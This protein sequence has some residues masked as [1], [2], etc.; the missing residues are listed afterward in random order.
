MIRPPKLPDSLRKERQCSASLIEERLEV[1][2]Q[3]MFDAADVG[4]KPLTA[5]PQSEKGWSVI[6]KTR[7]GAMYR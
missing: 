6:A 7:T 3:A 4:E 2:E 1:L 5:C